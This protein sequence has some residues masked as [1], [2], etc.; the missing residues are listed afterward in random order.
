LVVIIGDQVLELS[1]SD[2]R[3]HEGEDT[4][5]IGFLGLSK[6]VSLGWDLDE[7]VGDWNGLVSDKVLKV[8]LSDVLT[9][10]FSNN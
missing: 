8:A 2:V 6:A 4:I 9:V 7:S 10:K 5:G 3:S 1:S